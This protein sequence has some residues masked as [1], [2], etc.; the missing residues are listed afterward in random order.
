MRFRIYGPEKGGIFRK[1]CTGVVQMARILKL[2]KKGATSNLVNP[3]FS[4]IFSGA[5]GQN[6]TADTGIFSPLLY[7]LSYLGMTST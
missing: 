2:K 1:S 4:L 7:R 5:E 3:F 6:R